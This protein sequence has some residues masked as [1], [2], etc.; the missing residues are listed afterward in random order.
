MD[1]QWRSART[2]PTNSATQ[3]KRK[4]LSEA[5][6]ERLL[7]GRYKLLGKGLVRLLKNFAMRE[8]FFWF[9]CVIFHE[10]FL[11]V[12]RYSNWH[13]WGIMM[14][15]LIYRC[16][17]SP[18]RTRT[19]SDRRHGLYLPAHWCGASLCGSHCP[20]HSSL[21][22]APVCRSCYLRRRPYAGKI[23]RNDMPL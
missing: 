1:A 5:E 2:L 11:Q 22:I 4:G 15:F 9:P 17:F 8:K 3:H 6:I 20:T 14:S 10:W 21:V 19:P 13:A 23:T 16:R 12:R 18:R 7:R